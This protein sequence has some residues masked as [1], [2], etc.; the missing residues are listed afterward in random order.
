[1]LPHQIY[2]DYLE[3]KGWDCQLL[4]T[5][6]DKGLTLTGINDLYEMTHYESAGEGYGESNGNGFG[7]GWL[8]MYGSLFGGGDGNGFGFGHRSGDSIVLDF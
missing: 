6:E 2:C 1:M 4:R 3:D 8:Y 5:Q 7:N